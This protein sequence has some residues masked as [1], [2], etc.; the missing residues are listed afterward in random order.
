[1]KYSLTK[2]LF[3][4]FKKS[5]VFSCLPKK[6]IFSSVWSNFFPIKSFYFIDFRSSH[7]LFGRIVILKKNVRI[8][9]FLMINFIEM[10]FSISCQFKKSG[11][12]IVNLPFSRVFYMIFY[13]NDI[14]NIISIFV[15]I[16][17]CIF[18]MAL[19]YKR[20]YLLSSGLR[21]LTTNT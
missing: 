6:Y 5:R 2:D 19:L 18:P 20:N 13:N 12:N 9:S 4:V 7:F 14:N 11:Y 17:D 1:M 16:F 3:T 15:K 21:K 8:Y 10:S